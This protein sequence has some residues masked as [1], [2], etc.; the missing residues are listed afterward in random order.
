M[1]RAVATLVLGKRVPLNSQSIFFRM[2][3]QILV[4]VVS[5]TYNSRNI[6]V[7]QGGL[8]MRGAAAGLVLG[9]RV[10]LQVYQRYIMES[11]D[12]NQI[13]QNTCLFA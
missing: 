12:L 10:P 7:W 11:R 5:L 2:N 13:Y 8:S 3:R 1:R 6:I 9:E 4:I